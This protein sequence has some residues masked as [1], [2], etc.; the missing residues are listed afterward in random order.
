MYHIWH[1]IVPLEVEALKTPHRGNPCI[2]V[3]VPEDFCY[4]TAGVSAYVLW[5]GSLCMA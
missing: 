1:F 4:W 3:F 2:G 5:E